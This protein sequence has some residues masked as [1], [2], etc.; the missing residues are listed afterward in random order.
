MT[1]TVYPLSVSDYY[2]IQVKDT[3]SLCEAKVGDIIEINHKSSPKS[4][5]GVV[6][7]I[8]KDKMR[9][10]V[11]NTHQWW[12]RYVKCKVIAYNK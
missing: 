2:R 8:Y 7:I 11:N 3:V 1:E 9:L 10:L 4:I 12:S 5:L 6:T